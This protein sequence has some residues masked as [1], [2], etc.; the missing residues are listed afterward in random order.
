MH[1]FSLSWQLVCAVKQSI[2]P[3]HKK[4][5]GRANLE[6]MNNLGQVYCCSLSSQILHSIKTNISNKRTSYANVNK[7]HPNR[8]HLHD[9]AFHSRGHSRR[10]HATACAH[11]LAAED[12][13]ARR[14]KVGGSN[15]EPA[16]NTPQARTQPHGDQSN[17][18][19][20]PGRT[21]PK[22]RC[23]AAA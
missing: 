18:R 4:S 2:K 9:F 21:R 13:D 6:L 14:A 22:R 5:E 20:Q 19:N 8:S 7:E 17:P 23:E 16:C 15:R 12:H 11:R 10:T 1:C 3:L